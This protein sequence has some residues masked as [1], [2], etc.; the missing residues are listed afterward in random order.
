MYHFLQE[1]AG[2]KGGAYCDI[3]L[4]STL[5]I[6]NIGNSIIPQIKYFCYA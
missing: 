1:S 3:T 4:G 6:K 5:Y 2:E